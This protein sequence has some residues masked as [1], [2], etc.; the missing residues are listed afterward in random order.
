MLKKNF[1]NK[2]KKQYQLMK[3]RGLKMKLLD[4]IM[5][6]L[7]DGKTLPPK[8]KDHALTGGYVGCR[9]CHVQ[10]DWLLVYYIEDGYITFDATGS[11]SDLFG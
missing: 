7:A 5:I 2:F 8:N 3:K 9:E 10:P 4:E 11:H 1:T 6:A